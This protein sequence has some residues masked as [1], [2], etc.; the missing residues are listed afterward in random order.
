MSGENAVLAEVKKINDSMEGAK[1]ELFRALEKQDEEIKSLGGTTTQTAEAVKKA[2]ETLDQLC[3]DAKGQEERLAE[4]EKRANRPGGVGGSESEFVKATPGDR[5]LVSKEFREMV[6]EGK[7]TGRGFK[8][9]NFHRPGRLSR[10]DLDKLIEEEA[11]RK[12]LTSAG[13]SAG[14]LID[15]MR[16]DE[17]FRD[18]ADRMNHIRDLMNVS[19]TMSNAIEYVVD[20]EGFT[21]AAASQ[22]GELEAKAKSDQSFELKTANVRTIAHYFVASRQVLDDAPMLRSY[23]DGRLLYGLMLEEDEQILYGD[24]TSSTLNGIMTNTNI[25]DVGDMASGD[26]QLDHI[27]KAI[28]RARVAHY[29]VNGTVLHPNDWADIELLKDSDGRYLWVRAVE[30][31]EPRL[32]RVPVIESTAINE[33]EFLTGNW[34]LAATLWD[35]QQAAIRISESHNDLFIKNGVVILGEERLA[36]TV[37]RPKAFVKGTFDEAS[38]T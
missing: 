23:L 35:R 14:A 11:E 29:P 15:E 22:D 17:I 7:P 31:G 12:D 13:A 34:D 19:Q 27:R 4:L 25:N 21:N 9:D 36:L 30:G 32:W 8:F 6:A 16:V 38:T 10:K 5:F 18:P 2:E 24:G 37:H 28:A 3:A 26:Q 33:G 20:W 1:T